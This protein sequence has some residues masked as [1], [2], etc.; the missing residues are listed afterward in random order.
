MRVPLAA[1]KLGPHEVRM[2]KLSLRPN[3]ASKIRDRVGRGFVKRQHLDRAFATHHLVHALEHLPHAPLADEISDDVRPELELRPP[4][5]DLAC[6]I[7]REHAHLNQPI[8]DDGIVE[9]RRGRGRGRIRFSRYAG[10]Q[11]RLLKLI[12]RHQSAE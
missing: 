1:G 8:G 10:G 6:L 4:P 5:L 9:L 3:L 11:Y 12:W 2:I 7:G